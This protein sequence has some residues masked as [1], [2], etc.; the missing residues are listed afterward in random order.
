[1]TQDSLVVRPAIFGVA[2]IQTLTSGLRRVIWSHVPTIGFRGTSLVSRCQRTL[3]P[4]MSPASRQ[5][6]ISAKKA[7]DPGPYRLSNRP[8]PAPARP[9]PL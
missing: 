1:V 3:S 6:F 2:G 5:A 9:S 7:S 4:R 8:W